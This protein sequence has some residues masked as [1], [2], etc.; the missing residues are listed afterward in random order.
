MGRP[1]IGRQAMSGAERQRRYFG[2]LLDSKLKSAALAQLK[3]ELAQLKHEL[4][5]AKAQAAK[6]TRKG[7]EPSRTRADT[8]ELEQ[9]IAALRRK[10]GELRKILNHIKHAPKG[11]VVMDRHDRM[12]VVKCLHP[13]QLHPDIKKVFEQHSALGKQYEEACQIFNALAAKQK[14]IEVP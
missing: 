4:A 8:G 11:A 13:D 14:I 10:N 3:H 9:E 1:P 7:A 2:R 5:H 6:K 12:A